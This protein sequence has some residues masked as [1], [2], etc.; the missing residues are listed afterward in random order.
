M[1]IKRV[2]PYHQV[3]DIGEHPNDQTNTQDSQVG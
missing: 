2:K 1:T 3:D